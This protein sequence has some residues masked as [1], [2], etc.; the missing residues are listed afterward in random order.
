MVNGEYFDVQR[1]WDVLVWQRLELEKTAVV[2]GVGLLGGLLELAWAWGCVGDTRR[3]PV[4]H[5][6]CS[7]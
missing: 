5:K 1:S 3:A 6:E 4:Q 7:L 2:R